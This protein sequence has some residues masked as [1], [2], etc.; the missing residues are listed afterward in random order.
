MECL[1][2]DFLDRETAVKEGRAARVLSKQSTQY[3]MQA[4][5]KLK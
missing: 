5:K 1:F 2:L 4:A 3:N